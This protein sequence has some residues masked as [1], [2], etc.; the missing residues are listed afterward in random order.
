MDYHTIILNKKR[1]T[2]LLL[3]TGDPL[4]IR[5]GDTVPGAVA[6]ALAAVG[7]QGAWNKERTCVILRRKEV[8]EA[9]KER[10]A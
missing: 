6:L 8:K 2:L 5:K 7:W 9:V 10:A 1:S 4:V 3:G